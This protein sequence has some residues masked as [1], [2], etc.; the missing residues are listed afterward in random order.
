M[1]ALVNHAIPT[2]ARNDLE[3]FAKVVLFHAQSDFYSQLSGHVDL[4]ACQINGSLVIA[5]NFPESIVREIPNNTNVLYGKNPVLRNLDSCGLY[6]VAVGQKIVIWNPL[7][8]DE[9]IREEVG[10]TFRKDCVVEVKQPFARCGCL[11]LQNN[12]V[13]TSDGG[14]HKALK[15]H[16]VSCILVDGKSIVLPG[17]RNGCFGGC[18]GVFGETVYII[19][20]LSS[21]PQGEEI[22]DFILSSGMGVVELGE[23]PLYDV[24]SIIFI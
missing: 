17:Y 3:S 24:G 6:N 13:I 23:G 5:P 22:K 11:M 9:I 2:S 1:K 16:G 8:V 15:A 20:E 10:K 14:I 7:L 4:F 18:C 19:G 21:H 12:S